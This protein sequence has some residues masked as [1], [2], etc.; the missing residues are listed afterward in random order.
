MLRFGCSQVVIERLDPLVNP[1]MSPSTHMHQIVGSNA[2]NNSLPYTD[3]SKL[4]SCTTCHF[5]EDMS[6][7]WTANLYFRA[8]NGT[9][10]RIPQTANQFNDGDAGGITVY[11][12]SPAPNATTAFKP[13]FRMLMGDPMRRTSENLGKNMQQCYRCYPETNWG[14]SPYPPCMDPKWDTDHLPKQACPGGIRSNI[15]FP[16]CW[17]GKNLDS[18]SHRDHM[19]HPIGGPVAF[20]VVNGT[21]PATHPVKVPQVMFEVMWDTSDFNNK[22]DWPQDG[23]Q[24]LVLSTGDNT[25]YGQHGD[26]LFGWKDDSLQ[27]AMDN[28]CYLRNCTQLTEQAPK[29]KNLCQVPDTVN[30]D[31]D[32]WMA[33]LPG[34]GQGD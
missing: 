16:Q 7:Y 32:G 19:V 29:V 21:C 31:V 24:P 10:K 11:Y 12:T 22:E 9:Y 13:G 18:P 23:S 2:F 8:R 33:E 14:G 4:A 30:E 28:H 25:G 15:I 6:N 27:V 26:Y 1:G 5:I 34:G 17:D 20:P 3:I